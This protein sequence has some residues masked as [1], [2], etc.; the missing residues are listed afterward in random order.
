M[1]CGGTCG[2]NGKEKKPV[3]DKLGELRK[4]ILS[5]DYKFTP[6]MND[7]DFVVLQF[8]GWAINLYSDGNWVVVDTS[9]G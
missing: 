6:F 9:G 5:D 7:K 3:F 8:N 4:F 1:S 2:C